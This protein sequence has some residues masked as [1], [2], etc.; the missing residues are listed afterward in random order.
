M[1]FS[2]SFFSFI[3]K[4]IVWVET[5]KISHIICKFEKYTFNDKILWYTYT[6]VTCICMMMMKK[7]YFQ[8]WHKIKDQDGVPIKFTHSIW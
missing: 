8:A 7:Y 2:S 5:T 6:P 4:K 3:K 1:R